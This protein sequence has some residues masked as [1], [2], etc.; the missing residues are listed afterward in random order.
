[1]RWCNINFQPSKQTWQ[2]AS[3]LQSPLRNVDPTGI[4]PGLGTDATA[5]SPAYL[6]NGASGPT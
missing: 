5:K 4:H 2:G 1:M 6:Q 3:K